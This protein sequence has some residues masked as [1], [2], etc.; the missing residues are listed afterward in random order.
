MEI[1]LQKALAMAGVASRRHSEELITGGRVKINGKVVKEL[2]TKIDVH[3]DKV[4]VDGKPLPPVEKKVYYLLNKPRGY[5]T[6]L[7]DERGRKTVLELLEGVRERV[8]PVGRLDYD[9]EGLL[10]LTNDGELTQALTH[11]KH[12]VKK[13]YRVRVEGIPELHKLEE[14][15]KGLQLEDGLTAPA[16]VKLVDVLDGRALLEIAIHEGRNRQVRRMCEHIGQPVLRLRRIRL[17]PL[18]LGD[19]KSG[20]FRPLN[21]HELTA[22]MALV[23]RKVDPAAAQDAIR[24]KVFGGSREKTKLSERQKTEGRKTSESRRTSEGRKFEGKRPEGGKFESRKSEGK[25]SEGSRPPGRTV[26][27]KSTGNKF[28]KRKT[29]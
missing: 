1:R 15:A 4:E 18:E 20:E 12:K 23:G 8:Y 25:K 6:T 27:G 9:S 11:P 29:R 21:I 3:K 22:L 2:G 24:K 16:D 10:L 19:L 5:V 26:K 17:G 28:A 13:T 7:H 14:M